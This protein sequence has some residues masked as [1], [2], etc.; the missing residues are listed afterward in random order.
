M[1]NVYVEP[2]PK[3]REGDAI[4]HYVDHADSELHRASTQQ[5]AI[6]WAKKQGHSPLVA[7]VRHLTDKKKPDQW[8]AV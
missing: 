1:G 4:S 6:D 8:R 3:G 2:R 7:R 5:D